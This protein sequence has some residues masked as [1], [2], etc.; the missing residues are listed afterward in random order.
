MAREFRGSVA[1]IQGAVR[2]IQHSSCRAIPLRM[3]VFMTRFRFVS[4]CLVTVL[5][6]SIATPAM[7]YPPYITPGGL[8][9]T[10]NEAAR[11]V[12]EYVLAWFGR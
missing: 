12:M 6:L 1:W 11:S 5:C 10:I 2:R 8:V 9:E 7:A 4:L 3:E